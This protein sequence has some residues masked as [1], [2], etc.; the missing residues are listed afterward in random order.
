M[1]TMMK[2]PEPP[3]DRGRLMTATQIAEIVFSDT[4]SAAWVRRQVP[5]KVVLGHST[6]RWF[7]NDVRSWPGGSTWCVFLVR[8]RFES[9][10]LGLRRRQSETLLAGRAE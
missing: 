7:E 2:P 1:P 3:I 8:W 4:V 10:R 5:F 6:V 9:S